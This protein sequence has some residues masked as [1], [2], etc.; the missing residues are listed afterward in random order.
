MS[1]HNQCI[2]CLGTRVTAPK[3]GRW[4]IMHDRTCACKYPHAYAQ[5]PGV[6]SR[7]LVNGVWA[8]VCLQ[9]TP[10][11]AIKEIAPGG[12]LTYTHSSTRARKERI[13]S[14]EGYLRESDR[15]EA[16]HQGPMPDWGSR[17]VN[18]RSAEHNTS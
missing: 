15:L 8:C 17:R 12:W 3:V 2:A 5:M 16:V 11:L 7:A 10:A 1:P 6:G 4:N 13:N 14:G 9:A 18:R